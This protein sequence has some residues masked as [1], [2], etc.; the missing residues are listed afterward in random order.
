MDN[1]S[2]QRTRTS[3]LL[4]DISERGDEVRGQNGRGGRG[5]N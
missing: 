1:L 5:C 4:N 3:S 2:S